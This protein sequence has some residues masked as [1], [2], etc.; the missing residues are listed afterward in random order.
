M[1]DRVVAVT[2]ALDGVTRAVGGAARWLTLAIPLVCFTYAVIRKLFP[3]GH[4]GFSELQWY[5]FAA[6]YLLAAG[7]TLLLGQHVRVD[8][9][10][11][12]FGPTARCCVDIGFLLPLM[13][14]CLY[15]AASYWDFWLVS[16]RQREG[17]E[18]VLVG[19]ERW[20]VKLALFLGFSLLAL[21][22][23]S[24]ALKR[25]AVLKRWLPA[26]AV[27]A[28]DGSTPLPGPSDAEARS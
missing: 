6:V 22:C 25:A 24:E 11:R 7:Y 16:F 3:W 8:F 21:Q 5:L 26:S 14:I 2:A 1:G 28:A 4:N 13:A 18:D 15:L 20:P 10:W 12:R 19:L 9:F 17:P 23:A 27:Y